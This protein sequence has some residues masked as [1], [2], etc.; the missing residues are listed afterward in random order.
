M[1]QEYEFEFVVKPGRL[2]ARLDHLSRLETGEEP[3]NIEDNILD[4]HLFA[5]RI[6]DDPFTNIIQFLTIGMAPSE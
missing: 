2:N 5:I 6:V 1:F 3:T 4:A